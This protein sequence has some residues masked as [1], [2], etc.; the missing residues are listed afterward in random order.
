MLLVYAT[1]AASPTSSVS[2]Q[3]LCRFG[4]L[5]SKGARLMSELN[6]VPFSPM[7]IRRMSMAAPE[8]T[9]NI[10]AASW[11]GS[12]R[13]RCAALA[14]RM[15]SS[16]PARQGLRRLAGGEAEHRPALRRRAGCVLP[17][18]GDGQGYPGCRRGTLPHLVHRHG[19]LP[20]EKA[21]GHP[22]GADHPLAGAAAALEGRAAWQR[23][24]TSAAGWSAPA[25][26][27]PTR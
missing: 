6:K 17:Q 22:S 3:L 25:S 15:S 20:G 16:Q 18:S 21:V 10:S 8:C 11:R 26:R 1:L 4:H 9:S 14:I 2:Q 12:C 19:R 13:S 27:M 23:A 5:Y 24:I 7:N